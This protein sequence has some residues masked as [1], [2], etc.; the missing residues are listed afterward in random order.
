MKVQPTKEELE[1]KQKERQESGKRLKELMQRKRQ[2]KVSLIYSFFDRL[3][4]E[5]Y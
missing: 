4:E 3:F 2:E 1:K 5:Q